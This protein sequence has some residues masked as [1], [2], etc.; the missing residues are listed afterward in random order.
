MTKTRRTWE[1][2]AELTA[3]SL[4]GSADSSCV[5]CTKKILPHYLFSSKHKLANENP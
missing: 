3:N 4:F 5:R 1:L 2:S